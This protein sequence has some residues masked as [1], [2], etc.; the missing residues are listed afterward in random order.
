MRRSQNTDKPHLFACSVFLANVCTVRVLLNPE[1]P[2]SKWK[3]SHKPLLSRED[4]E[5]GYLWCSDGLIRSLLVSPQQLPFLV[6]DWQILL[7]FAEYHE[8]FPDNGVSLQH[9]NGL[10]MQPIHIQSLCIERWHKLL[11]QISQLIFWGLTVKLL[12][13]FFF[14]NFLRSFFSS[15]QS[16]VL[17]FFFQSCNKFALRRLIVWKSRLKN[18]STLLHFKTWRPDANSFH[19]TVFGKLSEVRLKEIFYLRC[20]FGT[21]NCVHRKTHWQWSVGVVYIIECQA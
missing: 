11:S 14:Q 15:K 12:E 4:G 17:F 7:S 19:N 1:S 8:V 16:G 2:I 13:H 6:M 5:E 18:I 21:F 3:Y 10:L 20:F 9:N